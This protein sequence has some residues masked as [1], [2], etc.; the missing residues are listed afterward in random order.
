MRLIK[1]DKSR[2]HS[3][4]QQEGMIDVVVGGGDTL[5]LNVECV[6]CHLP[7]EDHTSKVEGN[8][9]L[10][11]AGVP[12]RAVTLLQVVNKDGANSEVVNDTHLFTGQ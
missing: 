12:Q 2:C 3:T 6:T 10:E 9:S 4:D 8:P 1:N 11:G 5:P 7:R